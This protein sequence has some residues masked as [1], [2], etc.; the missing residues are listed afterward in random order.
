MNEKIKFSAIPVGQQF[1]YK[2]QIYTKYTHERGKQIV[3][4]QQVFTKFK[5]HQIVTWINAW[6]NE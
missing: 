3:N 1:E 6:E 2:G 4:K 5:K